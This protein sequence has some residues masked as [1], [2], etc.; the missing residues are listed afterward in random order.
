M[1]RSLT[2]HSETAAP[3][4][5]IFPPVATAVVRPSARKL[6]RIDRAAILGFIFS[7]I[8]I[9]IA[10]YAQRFLEQ[11]QFLIDSLLLFVVAGAIFARATAGFLNPTVAEPTTDQ[12]AVKIGWRPKPGLVLICLAVIINIVSLVLF[13][14]ASINERNQAAVWPFRDPML[15]WILYSVSMPL[16]MIGI[17]LLDHRPRFREAIWRNRG[18]LL[19]LLVVIGIGAFL[20]FYRLADHPYGLWFDE[21]RD[22]LETL[23]IMAD[24]RF[25]PVYAFFVDEPAMKLYATIPFFWLLGETELALRMPTAIAAV[26][27]IGAMYLLGR[28]L[29]GNLVGLISAGLI[30]TMAWH[31]TFSR[32]GFNA[33][34]SVATDAACLGLLFMAIKTQRR[35]LFALAGLLLGLGQNFYYTSRLMLP[36]LGLVL[37]HQLITGRTAFLRRNIGGILIFSLFALL[38]VGPLALYA[39]Q[40][41]TEFTARAGNVTVFKEIAEQ[42]SYKPLYDNILKHLQMFNIQGDPNGRHNIPGAPMLDSATAALAVLGFLLAWSRIKRAEYFALIVWWL[43]MLLGGVLSLAFE[44]PQGLRTIDELTVACLFAALP[45]AALAETAMRI[46]GQARLHIGRSS[47]PAGLLAASAIS[48]AGTG[49]LGAVNI[50]RYFVRQANNFSSWNAHSTAESLI[51]RTIGAGKTVGKIYLGETLVDQPSIKFLGPSYLPHVKFDP[52]GVLPI[53]DPEGATIFLEGEQTQVVESIR[54]LYPDASFETVRFPGNGTAILH[55]ISIS[56]VQ[57]E[58]LWGVKA[59]FWPGTSAQG[60]ATSSIK[61][62]NATLAQDESP[63]PAP[64]YTEMKAILSITDWGQYAFKLE[65]PP[66]IS[67]KLNE[68]EVVTGGNEASLTVARGNNLLTLSGVVE[69]AAPITLKW[70]TKGAAAYEPIPS[71]ALFVDPVKNNGLLGTYFRGPNWSGDPGLLKIDPGLQIRFHILPLPRPFSVEWT[72]K[73]YAPTDGLYRF[74]TTSVDE[75]WV[76]INGQML[77]DN[78]RAP[79]QYVEG[80]LNLTQGFHDIRIRYV[81]RTG[82]TYINLFWTRPGRPRETIPSELLF[83]P[84]GAYPS[85]VVPPP[86]P[87][88][89]PI[90][91]PAPAPGTAPP[92]GS[93]PAPAAPKPVSKIIVNPPAAATNLPV[94]AMPLMVTIGEPGNAVG[95][96]NQPRAAAMDRAGNIYVA[97]TANNRVQKFN[98]NGQALLAW[99]SPE[100][101]AEIFGIVVDSSGRV[102][103][104]DSKTGWLRRFDA[105][106]KLIDQFGGPDGRFYNPRGLAIDSADNLYVADTGGS[107]IVKYNGKGEQVGIIGTKGNGPG[108]LTEPTGVAVDQ[109]GNLWV[110]DV[111]NGRLLRFN[112]GGSA[113]LELPLPKAG[114]FNSPHVATTLDGSAVVTDPESGR[115]TIYGPDGSNRGIVQVEGMRRPVG[116]SIAP[117]GRVLVTDVDMH[118]VYVLAPPPAFGR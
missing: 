2:T 42:N 32:I 56:P 86:D 116:V 76:Y 82:H 10:L 15:A 73:V 78:S 62:A 68:T 3:G 112:T 77:V 5:G 104:L 72:G 110:A 59:Q 41:P 52:A 23:K 64:Y 91:A 118:Q 14:G 58:R 19:V 37:L 18:A 50:D 49:Y 27:G 12:P 20:R 48:V 69:S 47:I 55:T 8:A 102:I 74:G 24:Q 88:P 21:A 106:G 92:A 89:T 33:I 75:S 79:G 34:Y 83:P 114:S 65:G 95:L 54:R 6:R 45:I 87:V 115:L 46:A 70:R 97:D 9:G 66:G 25:R 61:L 4:S 99:G 85:K 57:A 22:G 44:A 53:R 38:S 26:L 60:E 31:L 100:L 98:A 67:M 108:Q 84:Q 11:R 101:F 16:S 43:F 63:V 111:A 51:G 71:S 93:A 105:D 1:E 13:Y 30:A 29:F 40:H 117:D 7:A 103:V 80:A 81:D 113:E 90:A 36:I 17:F 39:Y 94:I 109:T 28:A 35:W 96:L 107:R